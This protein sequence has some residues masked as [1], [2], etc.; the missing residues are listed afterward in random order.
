MLERMRSNPSACPFHIANEGAT[1]DIAN[2]TV[3]MTCSLAVKALAS[4]LTALL[5]NLYLKVDKDGNSLADSL[6]RERFRKAFAKTT[7]NPSRDRET[8]SAHCGCD[9]TV[10]E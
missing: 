7:I 1:R 6:A 9:E 10:C 8:Q 3:L 4:L 2:H 5:L